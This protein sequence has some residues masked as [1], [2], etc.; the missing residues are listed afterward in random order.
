MTDISKLIQA[1]E[2]WVVIEEYK[3]E[4]NTTKIIVEDEIKQYKTGTIVA[5]GPKSGDDIKVGDKVVIC[6]FANTLIIESKSYFVVRSQDVI[7][8]YIDDK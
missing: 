4:N 7:I 8:K 6:E 2:N 1:R 3:S 5:I